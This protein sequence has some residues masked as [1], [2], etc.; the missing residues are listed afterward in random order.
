M[1]LVG[2]LRARSN[3]SN[4]K[5]LR[6]CLG[7]K[8]PGQKQVALGKCLLLALVRDLNEIAL[9]L[10]EKDLDIVVNESKE[11]TRNRLRGSRVK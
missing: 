6:K 1:S 8:F 10:K 4:W 5:G 7:T 9:T 2:T 3:A 11:E